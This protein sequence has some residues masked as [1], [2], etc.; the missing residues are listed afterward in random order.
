MRTLF[1]STPGDGH[2]NP[3]VPL[4]TAL[5][6]DGHQVAFATSAEHAPKLRAHGFTWFE[7][8]PD[9]DTLT[10]RLV[11]H[12]GDLPA[13]ASP[14]YFPW[15]V[16][17]RYAIA[18]AR[19]RVTDLETIVSTW[20]PD[21]LIFESC[22]LATP[23][24]SAV[25]GIP[26][27]HHSF[28]RAFAPACYAESM[29]YIEPVWERFGA[30]RPPPL[31]GMYENKRFVDICPRSIQSTGVSSSAS[32]LT[33]SPAAP[34]PPEAA[35][36]WIAQLPDRLSVYVT[37]GT[38]FNRIHEFRVFLEAFAEMEL[39]LIMT[40]GSDNDPAELGTPPTNVIIERF[41]AQDLLL[42]HV[43]AMVT[44]AGSGSML[45]A[46]SHGVPM[47]ML[48]RAAD[49]YENA[50]ACSWFG[51]AR[52]LT[53][54]TV[55]PDLLAEELRL[56]LSDETYA[57]RGREVRSEILTM[58]TPANVAAAIAESLTSEGTTGTIGAS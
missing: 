49:Q 31:C 6:A 15:V 23:I 1:S 54:A 24:V 55:T 38:V 57:E 2:I 18:D 30:G 4:A 32:V 13:L 51:V 53:P 28:G 56:V 37:L 26:A 3:L 46:L 12:L 7:C 27:I 19:D 29:P 42:P 52:M 21:L 47:L 35:P 16:S 33:M 50:S 45:A 40:I 25:T 41:V 44:H 5:T 36:Q 10:S 48:P 11:P 17:R 22:D 14:D 43:N 8:G 9:S 34:A 58:P 20:R 39:N